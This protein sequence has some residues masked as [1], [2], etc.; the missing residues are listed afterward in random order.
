MWDARL[1]RTLLVWHAHGSWM[2]SF[3]AGWNRYIIPV[4]ADHDAYGRGLRGRNWPRAQEIPSWRLRDEH[5]DLSHHLPTE[6]IERCT[7]SSRQ[8]EI[9][10][11]DLVAALKRDWTSDQF[12]TFQNA[13]T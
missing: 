3:V 6:S 9:S 12:T 4:N 7:V 8:P 1:L 11:R 5:V 10:S 2:E 13:L